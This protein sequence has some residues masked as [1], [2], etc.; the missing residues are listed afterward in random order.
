M[1]GRLKAL[2]LLAWA[3]VKTVLRRL[4]SRRGT[5]I[6]AFRE[7]YDPDGLPPVSIEER[8]QMPA[9]ERCIACGLCDRGEAE[10]IA[11]SGGAYRGVM[12]LV[13][14]G[15]RS[16]PDFRAAAYS[17]SFVSDEVLAE[18]EALCPTGVPMR[19]IARFVRDKAAAVGGALPLP[20][21]VPSLKPRSEEREVPAD[22]AELSVPT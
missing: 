5:G 13:V 21:R 22:A 8:A 17:F 11:R 12:A 16:M 2:F 4:L 14:G 1:R 9:F 15:S 20:D 3:L 10:R 18:K 7:N 19:Q 6:A